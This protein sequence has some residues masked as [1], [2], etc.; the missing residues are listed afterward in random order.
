VGEGVD[1]STEE[2]PASVGARESPSAPLIAV[3]VLVRVIV[4]VA[5]FVKL[6]ADPI[7]DDDVLRF[8]TIAQAEGTPWRDY[9]VEYAPIEAGLIVLI[10]SGSVA[11]TGRAV[12]MLALVADLAVAAALW[13][14][15][16]RGASARYLAVGLPLLSFIYFRLDAIP[17]ALAVIGFLSVRRMREGAGGACLAAA[18]LTKVWPV[19]VLPVLLVE[20]RVRAL[21]WIVGLG[22]LG[23]LA[24]VAVGGLDAPIQVVTF[25]GAEGWSVESVAGSVVWIATG[26]EPRVIGGAPRVGTIPDAARIVFAVG[27]IATLIAVWLRARRHATDPLGGASLAA[28]AALLIWSP[29]F[30][31]QY[32]LWLTPFIAIAWGSHP[33]RTGAWLGAGAVIGTGVVRLVAATTSVTALEQAL[34]VLRNAAVVAIVVWWFVATRNRT[35]AD[36]RSSELSA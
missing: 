6:G 23:L 22:A 14:G 33:D 19:V 9:D 15:W 34:L 32:A 26:V 25:R 16:G 31:L 13:R 36:R 7:V 3:L 2:L 11:D 24:W 21:A 35:E 30:S 1:R 10:G 20:R 27:A 18:V 29:L 8:H 28:V 4:A 5:A 12:L 17:I